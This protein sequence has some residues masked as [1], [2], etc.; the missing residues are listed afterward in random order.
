MLRTIVLL[1]CALTLGSTAVLLADGG[2]EEDA[3]DE[4][5]SVSVVIRHC[6]T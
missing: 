2:Q 5:K 6:T 1:I 4:H 3:V